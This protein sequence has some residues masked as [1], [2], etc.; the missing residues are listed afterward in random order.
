MTLV[1]QAFRKIQ[2]LIRKRKPDYDKISIV[3]RNFLEL[4]FLEDEEIRVL[5]EKYLKPRYEA[6]YYYGLEEFLP[7][8]STRL[9]HNQRDDFVGRVLVIYWTID[10][11][12]HII[13]QYIQ[14]RKE[15]PQIQFVLNEYYDTQILTD[16]QVQTLI[17]TRLKPIYQKVELQNGVIMIDI[18]SSQD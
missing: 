18:L 17:E 5:I 9:Y 4:E 14:K 13:Q 12:F 3:L 10:H 8:D 1:Q 2:Q 15:F 16:L 7:P 11:A 6:V